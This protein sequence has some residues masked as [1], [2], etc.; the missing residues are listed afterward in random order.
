MTFTEKIDWC[1]KQ[2]ENTNHKYD[3]ELPYSFHLNMVADV[4][5]QFDS[6]IDEP[7]DTQPILL[8]CAGHDLIE[9]A[10]VSYN[11]CKK[12]LGEY[13]ANIIYAVTNEKGKTRSERANDKYY[14]GIRNTKYAD[15]V[16]LCDRIANV[17]Y[18]KLI[19]SKKMFDQYHKEN[20]HFLEQIGNNYPKMNEYLKY[21]FFVQW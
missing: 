3:K 20:E 6:L 17:K 15:F 10:R 1:F 5:S 14:E 2:H 19:G 13:V 18:S 8:A 16:K 11:D 12:V 9:D 21:L 4:Y 7:D